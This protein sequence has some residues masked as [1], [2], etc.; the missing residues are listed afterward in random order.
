[1][2]PHIALPVTTDVSTA[3]TLLFVASL[4][5]VLAA[6]AAMLGRMACSRRNICRVTCPENRRPALV[7][8]RP[9]PDPAHATIAYCSRWRDQPLACAQ[10]CLAQH[11][12]WR[13][14]MAQLGPA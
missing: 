9:S 4:I 8:V 12:S 1:M 3:F 7:V 13:P 11:A 14:T 10:R 6:F 2:W 5:F